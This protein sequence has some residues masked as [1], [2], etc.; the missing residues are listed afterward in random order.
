MYAEQADVNHVGVV[1]AGSVGSSWIAF[2]LARGFA[3]TA[4]DPAEGSRE[5]AADFITAA[6]PAL[7]EL[8]VASAAV[9][10]LDRLT[11]SEQVGDLEDAQL[12]FE[13]G[14]ER[15]E[16]K[17]QILRDVAEVTP[18]S[19]IVSSSTGGMRI[20]D[21]QRDCRH[22]ERVVLMHPL[23]PPHIVPL[24][25]ICGG[26][27]TSPDAVQWAAAFCRLHGKVPVVL[28]REVVGH[29]TN[30]LQAA[31]LREAIHCLVEGI[32][33]ADDIDATVTM[34]LGARWAAVG[35]LT[36]MH[37]AGGPGGTAGILAHAGDAMNAWWSDLGSPELTP[38]LRA[39]LVDLSVAFGG[40]RPIAD[41]VRDRDAKLL[42]V[43]GVGGAATDSAPG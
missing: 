32:A 41:L 10:P 4:V 19:T 14:P 36:T 40:G 6:W 28:N 43:L 7:I 35:P 8:G 12:I 39:Q 42:Q 2:G 30:R 22:P 20:T 17:R 11:F 38:E 29:L 33:S 27:A 9:P 23:N 25:E 21:L 1:G 13:A 37:L 31:L 18:A 34:G 15:L 5:R 16:T 26:D 24:I 3:V